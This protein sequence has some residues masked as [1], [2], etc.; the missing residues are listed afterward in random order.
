VL[1]SFVKSFIIY[2]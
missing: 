1:F 2:L